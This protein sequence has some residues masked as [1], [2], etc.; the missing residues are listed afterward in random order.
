MR[1]IAAIHPAMPKVEMDILSA[2]INAWPTLINA[3]PISNAQRF[4]W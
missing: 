2:V 4:W 3:E 1:E